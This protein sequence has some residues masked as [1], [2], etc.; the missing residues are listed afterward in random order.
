MNPMV[1]A[2]LPNYNYAQYLGGAIDSVLNQTHS[3]I[4]IIVVDDGSTDGS[5]EVLESYGDKIKTVFQKN[6]GVSAARNRGIAESGG[7][8]IAFLDPD[9]VWFPEK[10]EKQLSKFKS[11]PELGLV[12]V[13][14]EHIDARGDSLNVRLCGTEGWVLEDILLGRP[15]IFG[16]GS[17]FVVPRRVIDDIGEFDTRM[18][19][20]AD[21]DIFCRIAKNYRFG[22]VPETLLHYRI[23]GANMHKNVDL[24][25]H[26]VL[27][28][29]EKVFAGNDVTLAK[30]KSAAY[31]HMHKMLAAS[32]Y[33]VGDH[34]RFIRHAIKSVAFA[35]GNLTYFAASPFRSLSR[36]HD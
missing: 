24:M 13:G 9:D 34:G 32:Y 6:A 15:V 18:S 20:S 1:S 29:Y 7:D 17:G 5:R 2:I 3:A 14:I 10:I 4:E 33:N 21:W 36:R 28:G 27:L 31:G 11:D 8:Y 23:H 19:T 25:E 22:V 16:G 26:D 12:H 30:I 35:P